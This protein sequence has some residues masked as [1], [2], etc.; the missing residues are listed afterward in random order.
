M[1]LDPLSLVINTDL[2]VA[3]YSAGEIDEAIQQLRR[4]MEMDRQ[5]LFR[6]L[7]SRSCPRTQRRTQEA[8]AE[9]KKAIEVGG[10]DPAQGYLG[11][12][13]GLTGQKRRPKKSWMI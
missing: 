7:E 1:E 10:G 8:I 12:L 6:A 9:Y 5:F 2:G 13:Y 11:R 4:T 3:Y